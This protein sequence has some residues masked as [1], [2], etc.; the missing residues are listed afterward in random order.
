LDDGR[1]RLSGRGQWWQS[2]LTVIPSLLPA[3]RSVQ[4]N[5]VCWKCSLLRLYPCPLLC[6]RVQMISAGMGRDV[7]GHRCEGRHRGRLLQPSAEGR[8]LVWVT[9]CDSGA[10]CGRQVIQLKKGVCWVPIL[11][12][13]TGQDR[14]V[15]TVCIYGVGRMV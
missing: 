15:H 5:L 6:V 1:F 11:V 14:I 10:L 7:W 2:P 9:S 12:L 8:A 3:K 4:K 13:K